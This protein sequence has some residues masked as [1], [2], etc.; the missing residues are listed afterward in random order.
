MV[1]TLCGLGNP[2]LD[3]QATVAAGYLDKYGLES[4]NQI[5]AEDKHIPMY[6]ELV[7]WF[8]VEYFPGGAT[9]NSIRVAQWMLGAKG[10]TVYSGAIGKDE[11]AKT[12][13]QKVEEAAI[14]PLFY[15]QDELPTGTCA[16]LISGHGHRSLVA[17][18][19]AA[20]TYK[21][22]FLNGDNWNKVSVSD[23]FYSA[24]FFLTPP[25]GPDV[26]EKVAKHAAKTNKIYTMNLSAPFLCQFFK[27]QMHRIL[28]FCDFIFGNETEAA[29][30][31]ENNGF[32]EKSIPEIAKL[33]AKLPKENKQRKRYVV[34]TQGADCTCVADSDGAVE[35]FP[36]SKVASLV[37]TNGA[38]DAFVAGFLASLLQDKTIPECVAAG[39][40]AAGVIIQRQGCTFPPECNFKL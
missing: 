19:A 22:D 37:D 35:S 2:L 32:D 30:F 12:L 29:A 24:G 31:A 14:S 17:N 7:S 9:L 33:I 4:N 26:M 39:H 6:Q 25:E 13:L 10:K 3:I 28:P 23:I 15:A 36:V 27:D 18:L 40:W 21:A 1:K 5:L 16:A 38:G 8:P 11:F 20:N 34:I